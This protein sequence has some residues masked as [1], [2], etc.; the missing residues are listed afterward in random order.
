M[1]C[2]R[3]IAWLTFGAVALL[4]LV[5]RF[6]PRGR[7]AQLIECGLIRRLPRCRYLS[8]RLSSF[9]LRRSTES[10]RLCVPGRST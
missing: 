8:N 5:Q 1:D 4:L 6:D 2:F 10:G 9:N 7:R 3:V